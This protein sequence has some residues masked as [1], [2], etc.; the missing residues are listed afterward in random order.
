MTSEE[1][2]CG[3]IANDNSNNNN[4]N[5]EIE[6]KRIGSQETAS[7]GATSVACAAVDSAE[8]SK[9]IDAFLSRAPQGLELETVFV[10]KSGVGAKTSLVVRIV[11]GTFSSCPES[12]IGAYFMSRKVF[13]DGIPYKIIMWGS[14]PSLPS[15]L[16]YIKFLSFLCL[17]ISV[18]QIPLVKN[19]TGN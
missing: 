6:G 11:K 10:G 14:S 13:V 9:K 2:S 4:N 19:V 12:T 7:P 3:N 5:E 15:F 16:L 18:Q 8:E 17:F 1:G